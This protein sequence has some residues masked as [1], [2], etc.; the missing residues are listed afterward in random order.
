M[1]FGTDTLVYIIIGVIFVL[2]Q[3]TRKQRI[4]KGKTQAVAQAVKEEVTEAKEELSAFWKE[5]LGVDLA[6][7]QVP[8]S[9]RIETVPPV[10][11]EPVDFHRD[12]PTLKKAVLPASSLNDPG[13]YADAGHDGPARL[14]GEDLT[15]NG[16][17]LR[18]AVVYSVI[19]ERKYI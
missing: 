5:F 13:D 15:V 7:N 6:A 16:F 2:V 9:A 12:E 18:S 3:A 17:D 4:A 11:T 1:D 14:P 19:M 10:F 8:E